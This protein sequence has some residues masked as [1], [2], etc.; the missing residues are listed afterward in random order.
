MADYYSLLAKAL[1][2]LPNKS[3]LSARRAIYDRARKALIGQL[4]TLEPALADADVKREEAALDAAIQRLEAQLAAAPAPETKPAAQANPHPGSP[5]ALEAAGAILAAGPQSAPRP[6]LSPPRPPSQIAPGAGSAAAAR[7]TVAPP[8]KRPVPAAG[9]PGD[10]AS[11]ISSASAGVAPAMSQAPP[12]AAPSQSRATDDRF[13]PPV[14]APPADETLMAPAIRGNGAARPNA[15][16][17]NEAPRRD[18]WPFVVMA[19][20]LGIAGAVAFAAIQLRQKPQDLASK[21]PDATAAKVVAG[22]PNKVVQRVPTSD[23]PSPVAESSSPAPTPAPS[24]SPDASGGQPVAPAPLPSPSSSSDNAGDAAAPPATAQGAA[25]AETAS[26]QAGAPIAVAA[27][28]AMLVAVA[29][30]PQKP[31]ISLGTVVWSLTPAG[32][33][34]GSVPGIRAEVDIPDAKLHAIMTI[35]KNTV[36]SLPASHTI[37]LRVTFADGAEIKGIKDMAMPQLRRDDPPGTEA[38]TGARAKIND[39]YYLVGLTKTDAD[40]ARNLDLIATHNW[41]DFPLLLNDDRIAK[42]TF[43]KSAE[44]DRVVTQALAAWK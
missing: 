17:Q 22:G 23:T 14:A 27:R 6:V 41:F 21:E 19:V 24:A 10:P 39:N 15:P 34:A 3:M 30:D 4:R 7:A 2:N 32:T 36:A 16:S 25:P 43:E 29:S 9:P 44:G 35:Q 1:A 33:G 12:I 31:A 26:S 5:P 11:I 18:L 13:A 8:L 40:I 37:D 28:A 20:L 42:L 38:V